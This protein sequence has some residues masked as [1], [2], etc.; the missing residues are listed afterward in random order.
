MSIE[1]SGRINTETSPAI[2][3]RS[4]HSTLS[5]AAILAGTVAAIG[6]LWLLIS[7][8]AG[9]GL[10]ILRP[11]TTLGSAA[12]FSVGTALLWSLFA[13][14]ALSLGGWVAGRCSDGRRNGWLPGALV[15]SLTVLLVLPGLTLGRRLASHQVVENPVEYSGLNQQTVIQ[16]ERDLAGAVA[17][18][19]QA[20]LSSFVEEAVESIPT[21]A[22][23][24]AATRAAREVGFAVAKLF[25]PGNAAGYQTNRDDAINALVVYTE[26]STT[27]A[28]T[29]VDAWTVSQRNLQSEL[30]KLSAGV[31]QLRANWATLKTTEAGIAGDAVRQRALYLARTARWAFMALLLGLLG[32][33]LAGRCGAECA[34]RNDFEQRLSGKPVA[35]PQAGI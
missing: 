11:A 13:I 6:F 19:N 20:E 17:D 29:T 25:T 3:D 26:M 8:G 10:A 27:D 1:P 4:C 16:A 31:S 5:W 12:S 30:A 2:W 7:L 21:N 15:W 32:A 23:P 18:R 24:K 33:A 28:T 34:A 9:A 35:G 22:A 14:I